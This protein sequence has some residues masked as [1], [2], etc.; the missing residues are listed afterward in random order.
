MIL[1]AFFLTIILT[2]IAIYRM[3]QIKIPR[4]K[5]AKS[6]YNFCYMISLG[7]LTPEG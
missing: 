3:T 4:G 6:Y 1:I 7:N 2:K 5:F